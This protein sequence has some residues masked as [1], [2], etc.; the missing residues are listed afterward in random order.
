[1]NNFWGMAYRR[2]R[3]P[4][5]TRLKDRLLA[6]LPDLTAVNHG[7]DVYLT[8]CENLGMALNTVSKQIQMK[9]Q[10]I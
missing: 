10:F 8:F 1:M 3:R 7:R 9:M 2:L 5:A 6:N 4:N